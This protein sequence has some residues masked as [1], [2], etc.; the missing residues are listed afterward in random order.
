MLRENLGKKNAPPRGLP[1]NNAGLL[2]IVNQSIKINQQSINNQN[3]IILMPDYC[4][5]TCHFHI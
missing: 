4:N 5:K 1:L 2:K 3:N